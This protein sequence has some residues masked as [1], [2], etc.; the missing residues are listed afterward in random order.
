MIVNLEKEIFKILNEWVNKH[1]K[2][3]P[4]LPDYEPYFLPKN[5]RIYKY[6]K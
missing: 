5:M 2:L 4:I 1:P 3:I 6:M